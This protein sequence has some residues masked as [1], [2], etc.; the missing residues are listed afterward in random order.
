MARRRRLARGAGP[1]LGFDVDEVPASATVQD[2]DLSVWHPMTFGT[3]GA[4][5][6]YNLHKLTKAFNETAAS[7]TK[8]TSTV[9]WTTPG[10]DYTSTALAGVTGLN[11]AQ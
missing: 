11:N 2:T 5:A 10:G 6:T 3:A 9:S 7:W 4:N 8:A 1:R